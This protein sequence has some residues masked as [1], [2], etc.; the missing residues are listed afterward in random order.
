MF[1]TY[2]KS[3]LILS[4]ILYCLS[5]SALA[6]TQATEQSE[7]F[8]GTR[9]PLLSLPRTITKL[10]VNFDQCPVKV[11]DL[12]YL[13]V[14]Y[15]GFDYKAHRGELIVHKKIVDDLLFIFKQL[16][17]AKFPIE[18]MHLISEYHND[19]MKSMQDN[20]TSAFNCR[21]VTGNKSIF[22]Q[23]S[24]GLAIDI[25]PKINPYVNAKKHIVLPTNG[26]SYLN[27]NK[28]FPGMIA[29]DTLIYKLFIERGW[30]WGGDFKSLNDYQHF[31]K[32]I[33]SL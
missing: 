3:S 15:Y 26:Q 25:N 30:R 20:N 1:T 31:E 9:T 19:D 21:A 6:L 5:I 24:Y 10:H 17:L 16:Y 11:S 4:F 32:N 13:Q 28:K 23:H 7:I 2:F 33:F 29:G 27:R 14:T 12:V 22:S 8:V 18:R